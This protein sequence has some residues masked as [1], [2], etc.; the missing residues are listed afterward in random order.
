MS[1]TRARPSPLPRPVSRRRGAGDRTARRCARAPRPA[2]PARGRAPPARRGRLPAHGDLDRPV[3]GIAPRVLE[4]VAHQ[5]AQQQA[6]ALDGDRLAARLEVVVR[7]LLGG[8]RQQVDRLAALE[9][10]HGLEAARQQDLLDQLVELGDVALQRLAR[11]GI[12]LLAQQR[13]AMA[14]RASGVRSSWLQ[15]AS[16]RRWAATSSSMRSAERLKLAASAATS[17]RPSTSRGRR[18]RRRRAARRRPSA[19]RAGGRARAP[20]DRRRRR[21]RAPAARGRRRSSRIGLGRSRTWRATSQRPSGSCRV[22]FG[23][24]GPRRQ[25]VARAPRIEARRR[26]AGHGDHGAVGPVEGEVEAQLA[27]QRV[28]RLLVLG[29]RRVGIGQ[30]RAGQ[31]GGDVEIL[32]RLRP[33]PAPSSAAAPT[34]TAST[35]DGDVELEVEALHSA[36]ERA[37]G[38]HAERSSDA[39]AATH[40]S[41]SQTRGDAHR[42]WSLAK[43]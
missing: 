34:N 29:M 36:P 16:S 31:L 30:Q 32:R 8:E 19:A 4:Q 26:P 13:G 1:R 37:G 25:P 38:C 35:Q 33:R 24:P 14:M 9:A 5:A 39:G 12:G 28:E 2:R 15:L 27:M 41:R 23:P 3:A 42:S 17:S 21:W 40:R 18:G 10:G 11:L 6:V 22:K 7:G 20:P 43:T